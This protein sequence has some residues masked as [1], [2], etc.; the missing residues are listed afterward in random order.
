MLKMLS[1]L[2]S[3]TALLATVPAIAQVNAPR[4]ATP[5]KPNLDP[6]ICYMQT[7]ANQLINLESLC[8]QRLPSTTVTAFNCNSDTRGNYINSNSG[9]GSVYVPADI[10]KGEPYQ[11]QSQC[12]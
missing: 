10:R 9:G 2:T 5:V 12:G 1:G 4:P 7:E 6:P 11:R 8:G 3:A